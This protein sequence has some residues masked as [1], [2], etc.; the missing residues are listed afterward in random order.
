MVQAAVAN[1]EHRS[2]GGARCYHGVHSSIL[3]TSETLF[4]GQFQQGYVHGK[5]TVQFADD[6][7]YEGSMVANVISGLGVM[8]YNGCQYHGE[9]RNGYFHGKGTLTIA[10]QGFGYQGEFLIQATI[11]RPHL[12][13]EFICQ[14]PVS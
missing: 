10:S 4:D 7:S 8:S 5:A 1:L 9:M 12:Q 3:S 11:Q 2:D 6:T 14:W 13:L